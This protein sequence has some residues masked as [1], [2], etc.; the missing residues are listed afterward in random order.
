VTSGNGRADRIL[1]AQGDLGRFV[2][3]LDHVREAFPRIPSASSAA[4]R[5]SS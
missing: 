3:E 2:D 4:S 1:A 5:S